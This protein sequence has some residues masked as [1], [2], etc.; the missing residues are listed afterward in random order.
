MIGTGWS[1]VDNM[2]FWKG[3]VIQTSRGSQYVYC[4]LK[5]DLNLWE[6]LIFNTQHDDYI[7]LIVP[8]AKNKISSTP[9][10]YPTLRDAKES[11]VQSNRLFS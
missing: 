4:I 8:T 6:T 10:F 7:P 5:H 1:R 2:Y 11:I 9:N 3:K